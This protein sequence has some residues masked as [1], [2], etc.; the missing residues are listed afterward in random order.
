[1]STLQLQKSSFIEVVTEILGIVSHY[2]F[3]ISTI[4]RFDLSLPQV[5]R[6]REYYYS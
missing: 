5:E 6:G 2:R 3:K 1:L 4:F